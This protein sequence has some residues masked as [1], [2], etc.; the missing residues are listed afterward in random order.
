MK[1]RCR[2]DRVTLHDMPLS[3][4][5]RVHL[6]RVLHEQLEFL[7]ERLAELLVAPLPDAPA[8]G[9]IGGAAPFA[10]GEATIMT[11]STAAAVAAA[12]TAGTSRR[13]LDVGAEQ[14]ADFEPEQ[15]LE[16]LQ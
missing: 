8:S 1:I 9:A 10:S 15:C 13:P 11:T 3:P 16:V 2:I 12:A 6:E 14:D 5:E 4:A 7:L